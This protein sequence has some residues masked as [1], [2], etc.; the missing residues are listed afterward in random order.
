MAE[1]Q[2][3]FNKARNQSRPRSFEPTHYIS[4]ES[5]IGNPN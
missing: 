3:I 1:P 4:S 5:T 2:Y